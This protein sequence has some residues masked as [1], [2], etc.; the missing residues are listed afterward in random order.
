MPHGIILLGPNGSGKSTLGR[1]L[2]RVLGFANFD[3]ED[4]YF[5]KTDMP[6]TSERSY[7]ERNEM[8]LADMKKRGSFVMSGNISGFRQDLTSPM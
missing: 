1:E 3:V 8:L 4:Y 7:S 2:A 5:Y 6:Y